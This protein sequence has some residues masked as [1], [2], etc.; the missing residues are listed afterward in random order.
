VCSSD[1]YG[2]N[3]SDPQISDCVINLQ[4]V[5]PSGKLILGLG[6]LF[7]SKLTQCVKMQCEIKNA[8]YNI[9]HLFYNSNSYNYEEN[10]KYYNLTKKYYTKHNMPAQNH[11]SLLY[12]T[13]Y[14]DS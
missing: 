5:E 9:Q 13:H 3:L 2:I 10:F 6:P 12:E 14:A 4:S 8:Q 11:Q 1:L 7:C